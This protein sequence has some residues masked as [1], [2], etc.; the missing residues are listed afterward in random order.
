MLR[1]LRGYALLQGMRGQPPADIDALADAVAR[2]SG[3]AAANRACFDSLE[4][5][6]LRVFGEGALAL[7]AALS[8]PSRI[9]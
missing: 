6:P 9:D 2:L 5:N 7:D 8:A 1:E 4:V 3:L